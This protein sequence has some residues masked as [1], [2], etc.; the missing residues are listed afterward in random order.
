MFHIKRFSCISLFI[1][2]IHF[3]HFTH[4]CVSK[5][6]YAHRQ[7][8]F[9]NTIIEQLRNNVCTLVYFQPQR[10]YF[11]VSRIKTLLKQSL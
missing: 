1:H 11:P 7:G 9:T 6:L 4:C 5:H 10:W 3:I 8:I 2:M